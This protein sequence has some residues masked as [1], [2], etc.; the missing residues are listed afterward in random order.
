[1]EEVKELYGE[2]GEIIN[3]HISEVRAEGEEQ[4]FSVLIDL[5]GLTPNK[6]GDFTIILSPYEAKRLSNRLLELS[7][8]ANK[9]NYNILRHKEPF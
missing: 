1:M 8:V 3:T 7:D 5:D 2:L 6:E 4:H 9:A